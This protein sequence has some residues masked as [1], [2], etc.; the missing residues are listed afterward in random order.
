MPYR[1]G[2]PITNY[3]DAY[4]GERPPRN[5]SKS[6]VQ[7]LNLFDAGHGD[8]NIVNNAILKGL[9]LTLV[10]DLN[11]YTRSFEVELQYGSTSKDI[12]SLFKQVSQQ[13]YE[14][15]AVAGA[16]DTLGFVG[17]TDNDYDAGVTFKVVITV[18][19]ISRQT[20][21]EYLVYV[22]NEPIPVRGGATENTGDFGMFEEFQRAYF[23]LWR[24][25]GSLDYDPVGSQ[26]TTLWFDQAVLFK[27]L[28]TNDIPPSTLCP[29]YNYYTD[30]HSGI[31]FSRDVG[32]EITS[33]L[34]TFESWD[35]GFNPW[36]GKN[37]CGSTLN[38][39]DEGC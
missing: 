30:Y 36:L 5:Q 21:S 32:D 17:I 24:H 23:R 9:G 11:E 7:T 22:A 39:I 14:M 25:I 18:T 19:N 28:P 16:E 13:R 37:V 10:L 33:P 38:P 2:H 31:A 15:K 3:G 20:S 4:W 8:Q 6:E 1:Y 27:S 26:V 12:T 35:V 34:F 29:P